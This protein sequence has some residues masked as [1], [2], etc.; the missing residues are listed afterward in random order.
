[1][2]NIATEAGAKGA[3]KTIAEQTYQQL[4]QDIICCALAPEQHLRIETLHEQYGFGRSPLREALMRLGAEGLVEVR[5]NKGFYV[6][7]VTAAELRDLTKTRVKIGEILLPEAIELGGPEWQASVMAAAHMLSQAEKISPDDPSRVNFEWTVLHRNFH[8]S[9]SKPAQ[10]PILTRFMNGLIDQ[11][12][13]YTSLAITHS[14]SDRDG[15]QEHQAMVQA[16]LN[17]DADELCRLHREH[18][19]ATERELLESLELG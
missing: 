17:R 8:S 6:A 10:S 12:E 7:P 2:V 1:M 5:Q 19:L 18:S 11:A 14:D 13:R 15:D 9:L 3:G 16:V 4:R